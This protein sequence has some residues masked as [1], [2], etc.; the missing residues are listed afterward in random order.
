M[1]SSVALGAV[2]RTYIDDDTVLSIEPL[3]DMVVFVVKDILLR[4]AIGSRFAILLVLLNPLKLHPLEGGVGVLA[5]F[6]LGVN[7]IAL[8]RR[9]GS[10]LF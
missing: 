6:R 2:S 4:L 3:I 1:I 10:K 5:V 8:E 7:F 9:H